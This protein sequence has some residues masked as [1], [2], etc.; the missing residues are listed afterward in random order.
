MNFKLPRFFNRAKDTRT[1]NRKGSGFRFSHTGNNET[2]PGGGGRLLLCWAG[3]AAAVI[4]LVA[5][6]AFGFRLDFILIALSVTALAGLLV[7]DMISRR[8]WEHTI[9]TQLR[10]LIRNH[11]RLVREVAR[12]RSDISILKEGLA[13]TAATLAE[14]GRRLPASGISTEARMLETITEQLATLGQMPRASLQTGHDDTILELEMAPP[15]PREPPASALE[16]ELLPDIS[17]WSDNR[18]MSLVRDAIRQ[19]R[20]DVF[21]QPVVSLPQRKPRMLETYARIRAGGGLCLPA[22]RYLALA[23]REDLVPAIDN[24]LLLHCLEMLR[25]YRAR[26][27]GKTIQVHMPY[28]LNISAGTL[29]DSGFMN[30]LV[31]FLA[32]NRDMASGLVFELAQADFEKLDDDTLPVLDGLSR[33]GC[34]FSMDQVR[35]RRFDIAALKEK[36]IRYIKINAAWLIR[37]ASQRGGVSRINRLKK[38]LDAA[39]IDLIVN[40]I[41]NEGDLRE[42]LDFSIDYGQ[43]Y[44]L[45][46]PDLYSLWRHNEK[47]VA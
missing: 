40:H 39:G 18:I 6:T 31:S 16:N 44:L 47:D 36:H 26:H 45:G 30:D 14:Q 21:V 24:M 29:R 25:A 7:Y 38:Q 10:D 41:E 3:L 4:G 19:D 2:T 27:A 34:R 35:K 46:K 42:L 17:R 12:N 5:L 11:D 33:L 1:P 28:I 23:E 22:A 32:Q 9:S 8:S 20:I 37:E 13:E 43:G 15:P